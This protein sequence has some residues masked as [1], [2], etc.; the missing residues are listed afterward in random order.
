MPWVSRAPQSC[1]LKGKEA[2]PPHGSVVN[3]ARV[4]L[5]RARAHLPDEPSPE[6]GID[7]EALRVEGEVQRPAILSQVKPV[8]TEKARKS[9]T[10]GTV[11]VEAIIDEEGCVRNVRALQDLSDGLT[12]SAMASVRRWVFSPAKLNGKPVKVY[13][14]LTVNFAVFKSP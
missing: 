13:Y 7:R 12:E 1:G 6:P 10:T 5:C 14:V 11:T 4:L 2:G 3:N 8:Y 9:G